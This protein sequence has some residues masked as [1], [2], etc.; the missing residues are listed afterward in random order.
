MDGS[1]KRPAAVV[2]AALWSL[3]TLVAISL[4]A[5]AGREGA[6]HVPTL[7]IMFHRG[8]MGVAMVV[9]VAALGPGVR[10]LGTGR[11][12]L[13]AWRNA[14]HFTAQFSWF[15]ALTQIPLAQV[16]TLEFSLPLWL[17]LLAPLVLGERLTVA[18]LVAVAIGFA[19]TLLVLR[20]S[21]AG[22][23]LGA[24]A[25][26]YSAIGYAFS[27]MAVKQLMRTDSAL[28]VLF[29]MSL[30]QCVYG[31]VLLQGAPSWPAP[32]ALTWIAAIAV[33]GLTAHFCMARAFALADTLIV[34]PMDY[35]RLPLIAVVG[36]LAYDEPLDAMVLVGGLV[37]AAA[38]IGN[39]LAERRR[40]SSA[41]GDAQHHRAR[42]MIRQK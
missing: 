40:V 18:R 10:S 33:C 17:A 42:S 41:D 2:E 31:L 13:H 6:R 1:A 29:W 36:L 21:M 30:L 14:V 12:G 34:A 22:I 24:A 23:N 19:G 16:F 26:L 15:W 4:I 27:V 11:L 38:N 5:I 3:G 37:I 39:L 35:L 20:P 28:C 9:G 7:E 8:W 32:V 25:A